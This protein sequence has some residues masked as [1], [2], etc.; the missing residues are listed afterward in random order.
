MI[1]G[2]LKKYYGLSNFT[3]QEFKSY[4]VVSTENDI[5]LL[6]KIESILDVENCYKLS[7]IVD[8]VDSF[9]A[10]CFSSIVT[11]AGN[12]SYVLIHKSLLE[13]YEIPLFSFYSIDKMI[14][15]KWRD[16][17]IQRSDNVFSL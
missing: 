4:Y 16:L 5:F 17:W 6:Y 8:Y 10:N 12:C 2:I 7:Q 13:K 3:V 15:W 1:T 9:V 11:T 14:Y